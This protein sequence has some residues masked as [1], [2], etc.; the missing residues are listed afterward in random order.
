MKGVLLN[1]QNS[2]LLQ[3]RKQ[4]AGLGF[5]EAMVVLAI[6]SFFSAWI[7]NQL[8]QNRDQAMIAYTQ[9]VQAE[10]AAVERLHD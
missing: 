8:I 10:A 9:W 7:L 1:M 3:L 4:C 5:I 2:V 6:L